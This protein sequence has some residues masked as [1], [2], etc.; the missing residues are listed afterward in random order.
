MGRVFTVPQ[1]AVAFLGAVGLCL[2]LLILFYMF[3]TKQMCFG[4][5]RSPEERHPLDDEE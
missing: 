5:K 4:K 2:I 3:L 1:Q